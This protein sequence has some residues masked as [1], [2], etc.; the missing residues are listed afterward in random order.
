MLTVKRYIHSASDQHII[1]QV[2]FRRALLSGASS[3]WQAVVTKIGF[4]T[5]TTPFKKPLL[6]S[7]RTTRSKPYNES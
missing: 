2:R 1:A 5:G 4:L 6:L 7:L 3:V